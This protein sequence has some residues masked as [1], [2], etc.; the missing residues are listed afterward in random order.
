MAKLQ[1]ELGEHFQ[2][3]INLSIELNHHKCNPLTAAPTST[4]NPTPCR[5]NLVQQTLLISEMPYKRMRCGRG[6]LSI[7]GPRWPTMGFLLE[8]LLD[9]GG[10]SFLIIIF[11]LMFFP[12]CIGWVDSYS[13]STRILHFLL[14]N[15]LFCKH[16]KGKKKSY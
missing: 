6:H 5:Q 16:W 9:I 10:Y 2:F 4:T 15:F 3:S 11:F 14:I 8:L 13:L 7:L 12:T 1:R